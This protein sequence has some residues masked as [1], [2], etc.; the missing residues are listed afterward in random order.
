AS[1]PSSWTVARRVVG[2]AAGDESDETLQA[3]EEAVLFVSENES[4]ET[5]EQKD[6]DIAPIDNPSVK[7]ERER[8]SRDYFRSLL[9]PLNATMT[10]SQ[11]HEDMDS[12]IQQSIAISHSERM[13]AQRRVL[14]E[15]DLSIQVGDEYLCLAQ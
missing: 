5:E 10:S 3:G 11:D 6:A 13:E 15:P 8:F 12:R 9:K 7:A 14:E 4:L 1:A 2:A